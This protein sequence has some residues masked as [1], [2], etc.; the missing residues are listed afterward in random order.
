MYVHQL[1]E[2]FRSRG[3]QLK[4]NLRCQTGLDRPCIKGQETHFWKPIHRTPFYQQDPTLHWQCIQWY[5]PPASLNPKTSLHTSKN[6]TSA[7]ISGHQ[8]GTSEHRCNRC[9]WRS[10]LWQTLWM[11]ACWSQLKKH[12]QER[13]KKQGNIRFA[14]R[15]FQFLTKIL[16]FHGSRKLKSDSTNLTAWEAVECFLDWGEIKFCLSYQEGEKFN[17]TMG[18]KRRVIH[19][20]SQR[21]MISIHI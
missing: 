11:T 15:I 17:T 21:Q 2:R 7:R 10:L 3:H 19:Q 16:L 9:S 12:R 4:L 13:K 20:R 1:A 8:T 18:W 14:W 6:Q 5:L